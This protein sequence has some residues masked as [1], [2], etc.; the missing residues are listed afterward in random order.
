MSGYVSPRYPDRESHVSILTDGHKE[1]WGRV[2]CDSSGLLPKGRDGEAA[3]GH[4]T[5]IAIRMIG[6]CVVST[7]YFPSFSSLTGALLPKYTSRLHYEGKS[8][9]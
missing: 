9:C 6:F 4:N 5:D 2:A 1:Q 7:H 3:L 8:T